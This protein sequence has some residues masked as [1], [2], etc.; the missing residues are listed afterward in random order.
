MALQYAKQYV[1]QRKGEVGAVL[2]FRAETVEL[3]RNAFSQ[4]AVGLSL[5]GASINGNQNN[6]D[7][8]QW[9]PRTMG[10]QNKMSIWFISGS[11]AVATSL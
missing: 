4:V 11:Q 5:E 7:L 9:E 3:L 2:W 6:G 10:T 1:Q 8:E